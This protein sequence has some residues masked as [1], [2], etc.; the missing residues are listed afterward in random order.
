M[1][2]DWSLGFEIE[3]LMP[4]GATRRDLAVALAGSANGVR[5]AWHL[6]SEPSLVPNA[7]IFHNLTPAFDAFD[8]TGQPIARVTDDLTLQDDL[9]RK[10][11][12]RDGWY[13][14]VGDD[15]RLLRLV[16]RH[17]D[18]SAPLER[19]LEPLASLFGGQIT[20]ST[21]RIHRLADATRAPV[22]M[23][24]PLPGERERTA[25]IAAVPWSDDAEP[26]L[27]HLLS[28]AAG[29][30][31][32]VPVEAALHLHADARPFAD[33]ATL[34][35]LA[36]LYLG[37]EARLRQLVGTNPRC[38]RLGPWSDRL[39]NALMAPDLPDLPPDALRARL[40]A[41]G[42][43]AEGVSKYVDLNVKNLVFDTPGKSTIEWRILP[44]T[45][46][47]E[48]NLRLIAL[49]DA[50]LRRALDPRAVRT[51]LGLRAWLDELPLTADDAAFWAARVPR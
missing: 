33:G 21:G 40:A 2:R 50:L 30:G 10:A 37:Q 16:A 17:A 39:R 12:P 6:D 19:V 22:A 15:G 43:G 27:T 11:A 45:L 46:S 7:P 18:P 35:R 1:T 24:A 51:G 20:V 44:A 25:E 23:A 49:Y 4:R 28:T 5:P 13:R 47:V 9:D 14:I 32:T 48:H 42:T 36:R 31:A 34:Q 3:L 29:L 41:L 26:P 38:R 8:T